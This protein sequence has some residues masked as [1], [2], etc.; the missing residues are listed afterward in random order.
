MICFKTGHTG[1]VRS[2]HFDKDKIVSGSYDQSIRV[3]D[4]NT[5]ECIRTY[6]HCHSSWVFDV[7]FDDTKIISTSQDHKILI[8]D[9]GH[10][11]PLK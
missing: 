5:G 4:I 7:M 3:W 11:I 9:F 6:E 2:L 8:M 10:D 1:L